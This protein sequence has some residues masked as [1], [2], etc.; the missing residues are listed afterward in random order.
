[1]AKAGVATAKKPAKKTVTVLS[2]SVKLAKELARVDQLEEK[3][4]EVTDRLASLERR[5]KR[6]GY[7]F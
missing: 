7:S 5:L 4:A 6:S 3:V 2:L 1:M